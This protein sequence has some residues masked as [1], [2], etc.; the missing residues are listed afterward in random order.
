MNREAISDWIQIIGM[1]GVIAGLLLVTYELRQNRQIARA[2]LNSQ[3]LD[4]MGSIYGAFRNPDF[5]AVFQ[6][7][8]AQP[9]S[10]TPNEKLMMDG[11]FRDLINLLRR[12]NSMYVLGVYED[13]TDFWAGWVVRYGLGTKFG[14]QWWSQ[15]K[16]RTGRIGT[17][18]DEALERLDNGELHVV[19]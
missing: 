9:D 11:H 3:Q 17:K 16:D 19:Y 12:D 2:E 7:S 4:H 13:N 14:R 8:L 18:I 5:A 6:K 15:N 1:I 10:L